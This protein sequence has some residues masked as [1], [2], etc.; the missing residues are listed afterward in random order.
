VKL[1][2][3]SGEWLRQRRALHEAVAA[4]YAEA[5][6]EVFDAQDLPHRLALTPR[7]LQILVELETAQEELRRFDEATR[8]R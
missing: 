3:D 8:R 7:Q 5:R 2:G 4:A 1:E 6:R